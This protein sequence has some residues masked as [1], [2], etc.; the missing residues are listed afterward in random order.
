MAW[1][2]FATSDDWHITWT[3]PAVKDDWLLHPGYKEV[4]ALPNNIILDTSKPV[5]DDSPVSRIHCNE[6]TQCV[7]QNIFKFKFKHLVWYNN[8]KVI[9]MCH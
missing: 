9:S 1:C 3:G 5:E 6:K 8:Y 4:C 7:K 2:T